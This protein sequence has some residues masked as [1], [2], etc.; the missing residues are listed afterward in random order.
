MIDQFA[1]LVRKSRSRRRYVAADPI[2]REV[3]LSLVDLA[4]LVPSAMNAQPLRYRVVSDPAEVAE[5]FLA[6]NWAGGLRTG[7]APAPEER[8]TAWIV[9]CSQNP[10][11]P[12]GIDVGIA[13]QTINLAANAA[14]YATCMLGAIDRPRIAKALNLPADV[15]IELLMAVGRAGEKVQLEELSP[16]TPTPYWRTEDNVHHVAKRKLEDILL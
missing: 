13:A 1:D 16:D 10:P 6:T 3:L 4:R 7:P 11:F 2:P 14:G 9:I 12:P 15:N 5:V 8:A